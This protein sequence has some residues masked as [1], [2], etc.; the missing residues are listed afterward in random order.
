LV[1]ERP[2]V[3]QARS[4]FTGRPFGIIEIL[5][6]A[7]SSLWRR[8]AD[9]THLSSGNESSI[10]ALARFFNGRPLDCVAHAR[11]SSGPVPAGTNVS[12]AGKHVVLMVVNAWSWH[13]R[14]EDLLSRS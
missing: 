2:A 4:G 12:G 7:L 1:A 13:L 9:P 5:N 14:L 8:G 10:A 11:A 3:G 6:Y